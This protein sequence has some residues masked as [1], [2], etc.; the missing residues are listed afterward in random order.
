MSN[1]SEKEKKEITEIVL[2]AKELD[3]QGLMLLN[4]QANVINAYEK[5]LKQNVNEKPVALAIK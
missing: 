1:I 5:L 4:A 3:M 2:I